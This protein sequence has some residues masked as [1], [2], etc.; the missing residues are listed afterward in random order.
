[1]PAPAAQCLQAVVAVRQAVVAVR[2]ADSVPVG[3]VPRS[4]AGP[5]PEQA[6]G[7]APAALPVL[8][9]RVPV[10]APVS[11]AVQVLRFAQSEFP[12]LHPG[13]VTDSAPLMQPPVAGAAP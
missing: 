7:S 3:L 6:H 8:F 11:P 9:V 12:G 1:M 2:P 4:A 5:S 10:R 13:G